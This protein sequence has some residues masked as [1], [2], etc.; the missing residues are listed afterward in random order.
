MVQKYCRKVQ[1]S[2]YGATT[3]QTTDRQTTD[4]RMAHAIMRSPKNLKWKGSRCN[5][6]NQMGKIGVREARQ[7]FQNIL[8]SMEYGTGT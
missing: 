4:R 3:L 2:A 6:R 5:L 1:V 7:Q 8:S